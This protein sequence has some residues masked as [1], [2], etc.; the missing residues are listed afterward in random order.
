MAL[1]FLAL[2]DPLRPRAPEA[3]DYLEVSSVAAR[4]QRGV[5]RVD[6]VAAYDEWR[7]EAARGQ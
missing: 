3:M 2:F 7:K 1:E 4:N 6:V 5:G